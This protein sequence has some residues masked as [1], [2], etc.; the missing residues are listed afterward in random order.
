M[1]ICVDQLD[2]GRMNAILQTHC[3]EPR[4]L[5]R[6]EFEDFY[7]ARRKALLGL[8]E[9]AMGKKALSGNP[10]KIKTKGSRSNRGP[11]RC[12][13]RFGRRL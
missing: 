8:I 1:R 13:L 6:D 12:G 10:L 5:R 4:L 2:D 9:D 3:I 11:S 7:A